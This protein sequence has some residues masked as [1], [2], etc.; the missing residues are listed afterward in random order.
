M[1]AHPYLALFYPWDPLK[2]HQAY[3]TKEERAIVRQEREQRNQ[4]KREENAAKK[5]AREANNLNQDGEL[6]RSARPACNSIVDSDQFSWEGNLKSKINFISN[7]CTSAV[8]GEI[9]RFDFQAGTSCGN[10]KPILFR[11][12]NSNDHFDIA[13]KLECFTPSEE[14]ENSTPFWR[15]VV[16]G[17]ENSVV[18]AENYEFTCGGCP[19]PDSEIFNSQIVDMKLGS[20]TYRARIAYQRGLDW[21]CFD[22][23]GVIMFDDSVPIDGYCKPFCINTK[24]PDVLTR[25][26]ITCAADSLDAET[27][28]GRWAKFPEIN[29][30][31]T[32]WKG[33]DRF[34]ADMIKDKYQTQ[35]AFQEMKNEWANLAGEQNFGYMCVKKDQPKYT[36]NW[37]EVD[38]SQC[39]SRGWKT[40]QRACTGTCDDAFDYAA[41]ESEF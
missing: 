9:C 39:N 19:R 5:A 40:R 18:T 15:P 12:L 6:K 36:Q 21:R 4:L 10:E 11:K 37:N 30:V 28:P 2:R 17:E 24:M 16:E 23:N 27:R 22:E 8:S 34:H 35:E 1:S 3:G 29:G 31:K 7:K 32:H 14:D 25:L 20:D 33:L 41:C 38:W 26:K 13:K